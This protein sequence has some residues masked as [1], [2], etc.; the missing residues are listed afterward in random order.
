MK[1]ILEEIYNYKLEEVRNFKK[2]QSLTE[3]CKKI[4][5]LDVGPNFYQAL[6][7]NNLQGKV[8]LICEIKKASPSKGIIRQDFDHMAIAQDYIDGG[9]TCLSI[10]TDEKYFMGSNEYLQEV[11]ALVNVPILRK[12]F[13]VDPYQIYQAKM[14]GADCILLI[15]A[16]VDDDKLRELEDVANELGLSVLVEVHN[17]EELQRA[18]K[19]KSKLIGFNNRNLKTFDVDINNS[20]R[21]ADQAPKDYT[22]IAESGI[23]DRLDIE[24]LQQS[25]I[26]S[27][28]IG[29]YF[30]RQKDI[31]TALQSFL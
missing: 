26:N 8:S 1:N 6:Q 29:E 19:L 4:K 28:L 16:M 24:L 31:K 23:N 20:V 30:M 11:R 22:L 3:I 27:F 13:I 14:I 12:D 17:E 7:N 9:A 25:G 15:V 10:L 5:C 21:L 2:E 18:S